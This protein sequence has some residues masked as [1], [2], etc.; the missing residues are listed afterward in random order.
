MKHENGGSDER[1]LVATGLTQRRRGDLDDPE[2][3]S[4][5]GNL[6]Q[7]LAFETLTMTLNWG[8]LAGTALFLG[9]LIVLVLAFRPLPRAD[10]RQASNSCRASCR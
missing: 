3:K 7:H 9:L 6:A 4:E 8:Y 10:C 1:R 5:R 2:R